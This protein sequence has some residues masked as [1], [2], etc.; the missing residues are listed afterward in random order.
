VCV[1]V[2][3]CVCVYVCVCVCASVRARACVCASACGLPLLSRWRIRV[4]CERACMHIFLYSYTRARGG[5]L[6]RFVM[7]ICAVG[8]MA[9][10][11]SFFYLRDNTAPL[12]GGG[13]AG[14]RARAAPRTMGAALTRAWWR[15]GGSARG[16]RGGRGGGCCVGIGCTRR[17]AGR[18]G[19]TAVAFIGAVAPVTQPD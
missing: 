12:S 11:A 9:A 3:V 14:A 18:R 16:G 1:C 7:R 8:G 2:C 5:R 10:A 15:A 6:D 17:G 19:A 4:Y 13:D